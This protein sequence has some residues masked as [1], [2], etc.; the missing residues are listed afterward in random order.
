MARMSYQIHCAVSSFRPRDSPMPISEQHTKRRANLPQRSISFL[1]LTTEV[2]QISMPGCAFWI[3]R[4]TLDVTA[5]LEMR[6]LIGIIIYMANVELLR[7]HLY[8]RTTGLFS[9]LL[10]QNSTPRDRFFALLSFLKTW[11][12][13]HLLARPG[14]VSWLLNHI[15]QES[16]N[17][18]KPECDLA[19]DNAC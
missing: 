13:Q 7:L 17:L 3:N 19:V 18:F 8:W 11:Q 5:P 15:N 4:D 1:F 9:R 6:R 2:T 12:L 16:V 14:R 10:P